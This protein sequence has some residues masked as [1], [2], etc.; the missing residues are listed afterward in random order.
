MDRYFKKS[1]TGFPIAFSKSDLT[2]VGFYFWRKNYLTKPD[3]QVYAQVLVVTCRK[4]KSEKCLLWPFATYDTLLTCV[5]V[6]GDEFPWRVIFG[7]FCS[8][9]YQLVFA[10][11]PNSQTLSKKQKWFQDWC[12]EQIFGLGFDNGWLAEGHM[13]ATMGVKWW[14]QTCYLRILN[15]GTCMK[16]FTKVEILA[17]FGEIFLHVVTG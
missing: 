5:P 3:T 12:V 17:A 8:N 15:S 4:F 9:W 6:L 1:K 14:L 7:D 16:N 2:L 13:E 10:N 11:P